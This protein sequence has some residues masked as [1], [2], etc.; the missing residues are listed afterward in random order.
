MADLGTLGGTHSEGYAIN[1][2]GQ[3]AGYSDTTDNSASHAFLYSGTPGSGGSMADLGTFGGRG[4]VA[5]AIN[6]SGQVAGYSRVTGDFADLPFLYSGTPGSGGTRTDL[7]TL[8]GPS[9][10]ALAINASEQLDYLQQFCS[11]MDLF[12]IRICIARSIMEK[13][14][15]VSGTK[16]RPQRARQSAAAAA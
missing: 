2:S 4:T 7:G 12:L 1:A 9:G 6:A 8:G 5:A 15:H 10:R 11:A 13:E 16:R 14:V 3:V